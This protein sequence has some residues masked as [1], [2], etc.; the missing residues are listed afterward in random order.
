MNERN[1]TCIICGKPAS[2]GALY[3]GPACRN[4]GMPRKEICRQIDY[5]VRDRGYCDRC[6]WNPE[7]EERRRKEIEATYGTKEV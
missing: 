6:G 4:R 7:V 5:L 3:C 2:P 1:T